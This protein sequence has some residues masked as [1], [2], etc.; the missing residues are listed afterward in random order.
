MSEKMFSTRFKLRYDTAAKWANVES[1]FVPLAGEVCIYEVKEAVTKQGVVV[2]PPITLMKVGDGTTTLGALNYTYAKAADVYAW[3]KENQIKI[4]KEGNG[5]V[6]S[7]IEWDAELNGGKGGLKYTTASVA[8]SEGLASLAGRVDT[9]EAEM[10]QAQTDIDAIEADIAA[11]RGTWAKDTTYTFTK[12]DKGITITPNEGNATTITFEYLTEAEVEALITLKSVKG[13]DAVKV[14]TANKEAEV[15]LAID[16]TAGNVVLTQ[17]D[18][19]LKAE[20]NLSDYAKT[21]DVPG[22]KVNEAGLADKA[23]LADNATMADE[24]KKVSNALS[25]GGKTFD[26][27]AAVEVTAQ[28]LG[29]S[30][31]MHF[32]G[33]STTNP[34]TGTVTINGVEYT[35]N[36]GDVVLYGEKEFVYS[37]NGWEELGDESSHA[38]KTVKVIAGTDL[39]G[40]GTLEADM[41]IN[42][43][44]VTRND[45]TD[46]AETAEHE[47]K[48]TVVSSVVTSETGHVTAVNTKEITLPEDND[49]TYTF[50]KITTGEGLYAAT[51]ALKDSNGN[52]CGNRIQ[53][54]G[55]S[56]ID[57]DVESDT[58]I[59]PQVRMS[60]GLDSD[61]N[62]VT[63]KAGNGINVDANGVHAK[64]AANG[65]V[66]V[67][68]D[69]IK[70]DESMIFV[71]D[72]GSATIRTG[73]SPTGADPV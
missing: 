64:A 50:E 26:G 39:T 51:F 45:G 23:T 62:G 55:S 67:D 7:G 59:I 71:F 38:L 61:D 53:F 19:G 14:N 40:G 1:T 60:N 65:G 21:A 68:A 30:G 8:T 35:P 72:G 18:A 27:S 25:I 52:E 28:D 10:D 57:I 73:E 6:L 56:T 66:V 70:I 31:A 20:V 3:A 43:A 4:Q 46:A 44:T 33:T 24:A 15:S 13:K 11:N 36:A 48:I 54:N 9:L 16:P 5:N 2:E 49:T 47:G 42:H 41:T 58:I 63:V 17:S 37:T 29:I 22:I 12:S 34:D 32:V 69:G